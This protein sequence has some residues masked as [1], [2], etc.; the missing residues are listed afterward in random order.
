MVVVVE[1]M[2]D[3]KNKDKNYVLSSITNA[4]HGFI[5]NPC[6]VYVRP[7]HSLKKNLGRVMGL[8]FYSIV[9]LYRIFS[10]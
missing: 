2:A 1:V 6:R 3:N 9:I 10:L 4:L 5:I 8:Q 7:G